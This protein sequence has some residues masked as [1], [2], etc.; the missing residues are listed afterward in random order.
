MLT[1]LTSITT[2]YP[3]CVHIYTFT[4]VKNIVYLVILVKLPTY[5]GDN[6]AGHGTEVL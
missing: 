5:T 1:L 2:N 6:G 4:T 3:I